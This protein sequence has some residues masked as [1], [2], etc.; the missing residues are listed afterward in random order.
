M[1]E[2]DYEWLM[3]D[4]SHCNVHPHAA[5][6]KGSHQD[7]SRTIEGLTQNCIWPWLRK[8]CRSRLLLQT[9]QQQR[10]LRRVY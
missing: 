8:V 7:M 2:P 6:A 1:D 4:V 10:V 5:G 9:V 3:I